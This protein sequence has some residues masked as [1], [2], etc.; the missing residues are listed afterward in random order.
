[1]PP[2]SKADSLLMEKAFP[3]SSALICADVQVVPQRSEE[4]PKDS[5]WSPGASS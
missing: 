4:E 3:K 5:Q 1:M 2:L